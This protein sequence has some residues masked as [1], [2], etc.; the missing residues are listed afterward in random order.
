MHGCNLHRSGVVVT[1]AGIFELLEPKEQSSASRAT[2]WGNL[3]PNS[4]RYYTFLFFFREFMDVCGINSRT[5]QRR[6]DVFERDIPGWLLHKS[7][8]RCSR[9]HFSLRSFT[10]LLCR[11][12]CMSFLHIFRRSDMVI[13]RKFMY[14]RCCITIGYLLLAANI[15][16][17]KKLFYFQASSHYLLVYWI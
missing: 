7:Q 9:C 13:D 5:I 10:L 8:A 12:H 1:A 2:K 4:P 16:D 15:R 3:L 14:I 11:P 17:L 6:R